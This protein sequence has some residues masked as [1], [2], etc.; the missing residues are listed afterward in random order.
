MPRW[1]KK[2]SR[3]IARSTLFTMT[4]DDVVMPDGTEKKYTLIDFPDFAGV[5]P[6]YENKFV[7]VN[8]YR[9]PLDE[10]VLEF[11]AGLIDQGE[12]PLEAAERE[13]EEETGFLL[14]DAKKMCTYHPIASLNTQ[15]AHLFI[16]R[17]LEG[18]QKARDHGE[19]MK[20]CLVD[21]QE[22]YQMLERGEL[23]HPHT[24]LALFFAKNVLTYFR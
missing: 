4:E 6:V 3:E 17:A 24:M 1:K 11:P 9:Y 10:Y 15:T 23:T 14:E 20:V 2:G 7:L 21:I 18:G 5:L 12:T 13:L 8:N 22:A 19:D 16:G